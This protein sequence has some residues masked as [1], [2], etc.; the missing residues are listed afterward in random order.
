[1]GGRGYGNSLIG[2][3]S[4]TEYAGV[5]AVTGAERGRS[6]LGPH[7]KGSGG[8]ELRVILGI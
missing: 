5:G 8:M 4:C 7:C 3:M 6:P 1:M 2:K